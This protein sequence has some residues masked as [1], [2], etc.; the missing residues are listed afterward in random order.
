MLAYV[1]N[2]ALFETGL[3]RE[4][5]QKTAEV[6]Y[7]LSSLV[8]FLRCVW[9]GLTER[10]AYSRMVLGCEDSAALLYVP[11]ESIKSWYA[12]CICRLLWTMVEDPVLALVAIVQLT[13][14]D[15][16]AME[17]QKWSP[18]NYDEGEIVVL[19]AES[20]LVRRSASGAE[21]REG[22]RPEV[23]PRYREEF[24]HRK[25]FIEY[26]RIVWRRYF[27]AGT[28]LTSTPTFKGQRVLTRPA[29]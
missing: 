8:T 3:E 22:W 17:D 4:L 29:S 9:Y 25:V 5:I 24:A 21:A 18:Y 6:E 23:K 20:L 7:L 11:L 15:L 19:P 26:A 10:L 12:L 1:T 2:K 16:R 27:S 14:I 28:N 13:E